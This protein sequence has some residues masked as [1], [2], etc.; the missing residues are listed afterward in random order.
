MTLPRRSAPPALAT[1]GPRGLALL[2]TWAAVL[3]ALLTVS[4]PPGA[5]LLDPG[6][7]G[8][9]TLLALYLATSLWWLPGLRR[10]G[11]VA[12]HLLVVGALLVLHPLTDAF[13]RD[14]TFVVTALQLAFVAHWLAPWRPETRLLLLATLLS[15]GLG[16]TALSV[17]DRRSSRPARLPD[18]GEL[19]GPYREGGFLLPDLDL[20]VV[21]PGGAA[22][23]VTEGHGFRNREAVRVEKPPGRRRVFIVGDSFV[24]GYRT[25]QERTV[26]R[27]LERRLAE[28]GSGPLTD[29]VVVGAGYPGAALGWFRRYGFR[30]APDVMLLAVTLGND[31][32]QCW[33]GREG[34]PAD[35]LAGLLLPPDA[36]LHGLAGWLPVR[37]DRSLRRWRLYRRARRALATDIVTS[38]YRDFPGRVHQLDPVHG[39]GLF[40]SGRPLPAVERSLADLLADLRELQEACA[41]RGARL[42]VALVPQRF[43]T[44]LA[45]WRATESE[46]GLDPRGF[47]RERPNRLLLQG[48]AAA[49]IDCVD[50]LPGFFGEGPRGLYQPSGDMHWSDAGHA[51]A[52]ELLARSLDRD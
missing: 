42:Q 36:F 19:M 46:Y 15:L 23:F 10:R 13:G 39:L 22:E 44:S 9:A 24:A 18:Y 17:L 14:G 12:A 38:W 35:V 32:G 3:A 25:D 45:E 49:G 29:V 34:L 20:Q 51:L 41:A 30:F 2:L 50:L 16:E 4:D 31:P 6:S 43:Q 37:A 7:P 1:L 5:T 8:P 11:L 47:E 26:G 33:L 52:A 21:G 40:Y 27:V 48:C 28:R